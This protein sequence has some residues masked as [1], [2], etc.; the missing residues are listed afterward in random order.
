MPSFFGQ[1]QVANGCS[2]S[3]GRDVVVLCNSEGKLVKENRS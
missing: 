1:T 3:L 2:T